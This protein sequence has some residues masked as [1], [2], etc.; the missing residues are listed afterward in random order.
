MDRSTQHI[1]FLDHIRGAA[2]FADFSWHCLGFAYGFDMVPWPR[3]L[4]NNFHVPRSYFALFPVTFGWAGVMVF[5]VVS[6]FCIHLSYLRGA[7]GGW[8][9]FYVRRFFRIYPLYLISLLL[10][11]FVFPVS[12]SFQ[13][14]FN[15]SQ[16]GSQILLINN[17]SPRL[18]LINGSNWSIAV[19]VQLYLLYPAILW[20]AGKLGW[21]R[22]LVVLCCLDISMR[23]LAGLYVT[24]GPHIPDW[25]QGI[26]I[27]FCY[28]WASGAAL[29]DAFQRGWPLPFASSS[30][31]LWLLLAVASS[32]FTPFSFYPP[33]F[34]S[35]MAATIIAKLLR[36]GQPMVGTPSPFFRHLQLL[37]VWSY[38]FYLLHDPLLDAVR[39]LLDRSRPGLNP[40]IRFALLLSMYPLIAA[41]AWLS[42]T[43]IEVKGIALGKRLLGKG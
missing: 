5:F 41:L 13:S 37:G 35:V 22:T 16:I 29:A 18:R 10:L 15:W 2:V 34:F 9:D 32:A 30:A 21:N 40:L 8:R 7:P 4:P 11:A 28:S 3:L 25:L 39:Q 42:Y 27:L 38:S 20:L 43:Y 6:G 19:V 1:P 12:P 17:F 33:L 24:T 23:G 36:R 14:R 26:P 31:L